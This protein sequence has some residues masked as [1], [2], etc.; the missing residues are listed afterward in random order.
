V[1]EK[2]V[3][4]RIGRRRRNVGIRYMLDVANVSFGDSPRIERTRRK[5][6]MNAEICLCDQKEISTSY[7]LSLLTSSP[8][9]F[10]AEDKSGSCEEPGSLLT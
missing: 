3:K 2:R 7:I 1:K 10:I 6:C 8:D 9:F 4:L 5:D